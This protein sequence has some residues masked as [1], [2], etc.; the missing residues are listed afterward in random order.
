[1]FFLIAVIILHNILAS[2]LRAEGLDLVDI[3]S[4]RHGRRL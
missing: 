1:M 4:E 2:L 3:L